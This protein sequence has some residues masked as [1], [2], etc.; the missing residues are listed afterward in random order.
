MAENGI[1]DR[2]VTAV[3]LRFKIC[4]QGREVALFC[5]FNFNDNLIRSS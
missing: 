3:N 4:G 1:D 2:F 5:V